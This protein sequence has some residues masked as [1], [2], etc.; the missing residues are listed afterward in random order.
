VVVLSANH[1]S[2]TVFHAGLV[3]TGDDNFTAEDAEIAELIIFSASSAF[4]AVILR[5]E[6]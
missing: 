1:I 4:S 3:A 6:M 2:R 5:A